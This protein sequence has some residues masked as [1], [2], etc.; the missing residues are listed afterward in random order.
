MALIGLMVLMK[1]KHPFLKR[2]TLSLRTEKLRQ[3]I[4]K[5]AKI[6]VKTRH[7]TLR[8]LNLPKKTKHLILKPTKVHGN[9]RPV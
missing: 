2:Q 6:P 1:T 3:L 5:T 4:L 7:L 8:P 9:Q